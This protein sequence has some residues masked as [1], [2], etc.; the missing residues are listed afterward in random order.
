MTTRGAVLRLG[1]G[2]ETTVTLRDVEHQDAAGS[3][4]FLIVLES[5]GLRAAAPVSTYESAD[6][7]LAAFIETLAVQWRGWSGVQTWDPHGTLSVEARHDDRGYAHVRFTLCEHREP[8][9]WTA[10]IE[11]SLTAG[12]ELPGTAAAL[13]ALLHPSDDR[14]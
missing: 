11:I 9:G 6:H 2:S 12:E 1:D 5:P 13:K 14:E 4:R 8:H 3:V 10:S 7:G